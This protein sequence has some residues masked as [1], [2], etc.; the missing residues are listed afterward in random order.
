[1]RLW[2]SSSGYAINVSIPFLLQHTRMISCQD[3]SQSNVKLV[4]YFFLQSKVEEINSQLNQEYTLRRSM[5]L[6]RLD[7]TVQSFGWSDRAKVCTSLYMNFLVTMNLVKFE[8]KS[9]SNLYISRLKNMKCLQF[10]IH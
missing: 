5:L 7:V 1:M 4:T 9:Y 2:E 3:I 10:F 6:K 8:S